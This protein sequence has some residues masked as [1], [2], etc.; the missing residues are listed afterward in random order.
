M[1]LV[2]VHRQRLAQAVD[3]LG[4]LANRLLPLVAGILLGKQVLLRRFQFSGA[5]LLLG[6]I[7]GE[8]LH[9]L[10]MAEGQRLAV[11][12]RLADLYADSALL[13]A[14]A[15]AILIERVCVAFAG[16]QRHA[17]VL[18]FLTQRVQRLALF[19]QRVAHRGGLFVHFLV[20]L[21]LARLCIAR[22]RKLAVDLFEVLRNLFAQQFASILLRAM[23]FAL[24]V[25]RAHALLR[26]GNV[27]LRLPDILKRLCAALLD[28]LTD[29][30]APFQTAGAVG[31]L[32]FQLDKQLF[33]LLDFAFAG[34]QAGH[35]GGA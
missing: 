4:Q 28:L 35:A 9:A 2:H 31:D 20:G 16:R 6:G 7:P 17:E 3:F 10:L 1:A 13:P 23:L 18:C 29:R 30:L 22:A 14:H 33:M 12:M 21:L 8:L 15:R 27:N 5:R 26:D 25:Q 11:L 19:I 24:H 34:K 32:L